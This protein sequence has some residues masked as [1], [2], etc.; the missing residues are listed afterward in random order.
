MPKEENSKN[1]N[2]VEGCIIY[3][4]LAFV[5]SCGILLINTFHGDP[6]IYLIYA[7]N[8]VEGELLAFNPGQFSSGATSP[9]WGSILSVGFLTSHGVLLAKLIS[10]IATMIAV[11]VCY[12]TLL[13][14]SKSRLGS[15]SGAALTAYLLALPGLLMYESSLIVILIYL[16]ILKSYRI[17]SEQK[18]SRSLAATCVIWALIP[19]TRPDAI[20]IVII[21]FLVLT[22]YFY[23]QRRMDIIR[24]LPLLLLVSSVPALIYYGYS[25]SHSGI[26]STS[27]ICRAFSI[28]EN[29]ASLGGFSYSLEALRFFLGSSMII[30]LCLSLWGLV[31]LTSRRETKPFY[32][33]SILCV[34]S[35]FISLSLISPVTSGI[36]RYILPVIPFVALPASIAVREIY[37]S[38]TGKKRR[39]FLAFFFVILILQPMF[40]IVKSSLKWSKLG[41][42]F[43]VVTERDIIEY[44]NS[45]VEKDA[46]VLIY[47]VQDRYYLRRDISL[48]SLD[49]ITDGKVAPYLYDKDMYGFLLKYRPDYWLANDA[50]HYRP[51]LSGSMLRKVFDETESGN[52]ITVQIGKITFTRIKARNTPPVPGFS[53]Y[54]QLYKIDYAR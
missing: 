38:I 42:S 4:I 46:T 27:A 29:A 34:A 13:A 17:F 1:G 30:F 43:E 11:Y 26:F 7:R 52:N 35:Y 10:L 33:F 2:R 48:L 18:A 9:L 8:M 54:R 47:E 19:I 14:I 31:D 37:A 24:R 50:V 39:L 51:Y 21:H 15:V 23:K 36:T 6:I 5:L 3:L 40:S 49:G 16:L 22:Y 20:M 44:M 45:I 28:R 12:R 41:L 25:F 32:G 53:E